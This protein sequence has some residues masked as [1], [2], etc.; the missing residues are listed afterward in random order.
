[1]IVVPRARP[2]EDLAGAPGKLLGTMI[3]VTTAGLLDPVRFRRGREYANEGAV[4]SMSIESGSLTAIVQGSRREPYEVTVRTATVPPLAAGV[5]PA[6]MPTLA[7]GPGDVRTS[8]SC[9][10]AADG[11][12]KHAAAV[13]LAFADEVSL[14]PELL[15]AWRCGTGAP[16]V[17]AA[18]G[19]RRPAPGRAAP[20]PPPASPFE[21]DEWA[22][23]VSAPAAI[24]LDDLL[25]TVRAA[26]PATVGSERLGAVDLSAM[27]RSALAAMRAAGDVL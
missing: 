21:T 7:P 1:V 14:R 20:A 4:G 26:P 22:S 3:S 18:V 23:F 10:D 11:T 24:D 19:S 25:T 27:V 6:A 15:V 8:C 13:L 2:R 16:A 17:R 12:C 5:N 9:P